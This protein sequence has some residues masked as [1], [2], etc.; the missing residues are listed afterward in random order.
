MPNTKQS[1]LIAALHHSGA[2]LLY[3][4][5]AVYLYQPYFKNFNALRFLIVI[6]A[7]LAS[8]GGYVLSRR[9]I[10]S[11][12]CSFFAGASYG[13]GPFAL[14]LAGYHPTA[15]LLVAAVPWFFCPA[16]FGPTCGRAKAKWRWVGRLLSALPFLAILSFFQLSA[17]WRLF[18]IPVQTELNL[19]DLAF[20]LAPLAAAERGLT[21]VGFYHVPM[22]FLIVGGSML[23]AARRFGILA[24]FAVGVILGFCNPVF[25]VSPIIWLTIPLLCCSILIGAGME[26]IVCTDFADRKLLLATAAVMAALSIVTLLLATEC[27][28]I[29]AGLGAKYGR[30]FTEA[31]KMYILGA[32]TITIIFFAARAKL[33]IHLLRLA[34]LC[35]AAA[36]DIFLGA[37]FIV[38]STF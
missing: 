37:R 27:F 20:L 9:W 17:R 10:T 12:W 31:A 28:Q 8:L 5:F 19:A 18:A 7:C 11:F 21:A 15:G 6:N 32:I 24:I 3:A 1:Y 38:D 29:F 13:F 22:A 34:V 26:G 23:V 4:G 14:W 33:R 16:A 36:I 35:S 25:N 2:A 30:C